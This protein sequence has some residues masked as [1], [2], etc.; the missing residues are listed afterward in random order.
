MRFTAGGE[1]LDQ[2]NQRSTFNVRGAEQSDPEIA[3]PKPASK[4][5]RWPPFSWTTDDDKGGLQSSQPGDYDGSS[6]VPESR[7]VAPVSERRPPILNHRSNSS[8]D[9]QSAEEFKIEEVK[10]VA[11]RPSVFELS[12]QE[13]AQRLARSVGTHSAPGSRTASPARIDG[14]ISSSPLG[15]R[16]YALQPQDIPMVNMKGKDVRN[17]DED[18]EDDDEDPSRRRRN[19]SSTSEAHRLVR[20]HTKRGSA[21]SF[22]THVSSPGQRSGQVT[23]LG[24]RDP[25]TYVPPPRHY[26][27]GI[28]SSLL[29]LYDEQGLGAAISD[30]P[31]GSA[32]RRARHLRGSSVDTIANTPTPRVTPHSS[33][34][35]SGRNTP[36]PKNPKWYKSPNH[37][38][39]SLSG[40]ISS[41]TMLAQPGGAAA[42]PK[43]NLHHPPVPRPKSTNPIGA[44]F[45]R[46]SKPRLED[47]IRITIH[48]AET[49]SRQ[50]FLVKLCRALMKYGAPTHRLEGEL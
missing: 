34:P 6:D 18:T 22:R 13:R 10:D 15:P 37:S 43:P 26:R 21:N 12:A 4:P 50:K 40:L 36:K 1:S 16:G 11:G 35:S 31:S 2:R 9:F 8:G 29:K 49:L 48:I 3:Q 47:E 24:D 42:A 45:S 27:G 7:P 41:S 25:D 19:Q 30:T 32:P 39:T 46:I 38:T 20:Q 5:R 28:L 17:A 44:A 33:P 23:P 14:G